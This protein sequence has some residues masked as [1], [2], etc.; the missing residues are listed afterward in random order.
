MKKNAKSII[1]FDLDM[2]LLDHETWEIPESALKAVK[3]LHPDHV[4]VIASGRDMDTPFSS[5]YRD[6]IAPDAIIHMNGSRIEAEGKELYRHHMSPQLLKNLID[7]GKAHKHCIG[8]MIDGIDYYTWSELLAERDA[9]FWGQSDRIFGDP[10][11][12]L[13][14]RPGALAYFG[15]EAGVNEIESAFPE[16]NLPMFAR[17]QGADVIEKNLSKAMGLEML[18]EYYGIDMKNTVAFGDSMND[19]EIVKAAGL[20][21]AMGNAIDALKKAADYVTTEVYRDGIFNACRKLELFG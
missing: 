18:C 13:S 11:E 19:Y 5:K 17:K 7:Y 12:L 1:C 8:T 15:D 2:T 9:L 4:I 14:L 21:I 10:D 16:L 3:K 20:G 6:Q